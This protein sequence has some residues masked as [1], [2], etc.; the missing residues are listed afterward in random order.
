MQ[1][2]KL[3]KYLSELF[4]PVDF[5]KKTIPD[6][7]ARQTQENLL[8]QSMSKELDLIQEVVQ[9]DVDQT[10]AW[11]KLEGFRGLAEV[12]RQQA[13]DGEALLTLT[14]AD[15]VKLFNSPLPNLCLKL[16][17]L[18][19]AYNLHRQT[20]ELDTRISSLEQSRATR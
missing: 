19:I 10:I 6:K 14:A 3:L 12:V 7:K 11:F 16:E 17:I 9:W 8:I 13:V 20:R 5:T 1:M 15:V 18:S 4:S 2:I